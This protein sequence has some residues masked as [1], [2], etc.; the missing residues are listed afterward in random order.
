MGSISSF[1]RENER[2][3]RLSSLEGDLHGVGSIDRREAEAITDRFR[4]AKS[5]L[6]KHHNYQ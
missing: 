4:S 1:E 2:K 5:V 3:T 6:K